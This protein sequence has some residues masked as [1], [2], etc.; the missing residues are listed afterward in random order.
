MWGTHALNNTAK[1]LLK[2]NQHQEGPGIAKS[3]AIAKEYLKIRA[4]AIHL[5]LNLFSII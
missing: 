5:F 3:M 4:S 1:I 2:Y